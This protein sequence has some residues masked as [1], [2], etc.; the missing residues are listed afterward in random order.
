LGHR[1]HGD[2]SIAVDDGIQLATA[3][4]ITA[5][6]QKELFA[7]LPELATAAVRFAAGRRD[8]ERA[9]HGA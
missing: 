9:I 7:H 3:N 1:L 6:V 5:S 4:D 8:A 2:V